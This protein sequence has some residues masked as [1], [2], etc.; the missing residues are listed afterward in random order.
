MRARQLGQEH[1][2]VLESGE[3]ALE[4]MT[5]Y[6]KQHRIAAGRFSAIGGF[7]HVELGYFNTQK[8]QAEHMKMDKQVEVV[9]MIG[10][11][12]LLDG[13]PH[14]HAHVSVSDQTFQ[15]YSGHLGEGIV[16]PTLEVFLTQFTSPILREKDEQTGQ[17][18]LHPEP[19][20]QVL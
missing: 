15:A 1:V 20:V 2:L 5:T 18:E 8:N 12:A 4:A 13:E 6:L 3:P 7:S 17:M 16:E 9:S 10:N 19:G 11:I 14:V